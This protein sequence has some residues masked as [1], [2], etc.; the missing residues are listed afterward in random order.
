MSETT[1]AN[2]V[3]FPLI[4][5]HE[6][7]CSLRKSENLETSLVE[8]NKSVYIRDK[9]I[10][11][12]RFNTTLNV[13]QSIIDWGVAVFN[14]TTTE[15]GKSYLNAFFNRTPGGIIVDIGKII[16][17]IQD[18][19]NFESAIS[20][21]IDTTQKCAMMWFKI[22]AV[23]TLFLI[24]AA[25]GI[26]Y[27]WDQSVVKDIIPGIMDI[28]AQLKIISP[29]TSEKMIQLLTVKIKEPLVIIRGRSMPSILQMIETTQWGIH[30]ILH[31]TA[32]ASQTIIQNPANRRVS[33]MISTA[34]RK[35]KARIP[36]IPDL[37]KTAIEFCIGFMKMMAS[38]TYET[39]E[40]VWTEIKPAIMGL[41]TSI[42]SAGKLISDIY[43]K[44]FWATVFKAGMDETDFDADENWDNFD[45]YEGQ[46]STADQEADKATLLI[47]KITLDLHLIQNHATRTDADV[48]RNKKSTNIAFGIV[49]KILSLIMTIIKSCAG[50]VLRQL[51]TSSVIAISSTGGAALPAAAIA[52]FSFLAVVLGIGMCTSYIQHKIVAKSCA[53]AYRLA[54]GESKYELRRKCEENVANG[55]LDSVEM[56]LQLLYDSSIPFS[57][58][59]TSVKY[60]STYIIDGI[61]KTEEQVYIQNDLN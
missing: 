37:I 41:S 45:I 32:V 40:I 8:K 19:S 16:S 12:E 10:V 9:T 53:D 29:E 42:S 30:A 24:I 7:V 21:A 61:R 1:S 6:K 13:C 3:C 54:P 20:I 59:G 57:L 60:V 11:Y 26:C 4:C 15:Q 38:K 56:I 23:L 34:A 44:G 39:V 47:R 48:N 50:R 46:F 5:M 28:L 22:F 49:Y 31:G 36:Q 17:S 55:T 33:E 2:I 18:L 51:I 52:I 14:I 35:I 25:L 27:F 43:T 58:G